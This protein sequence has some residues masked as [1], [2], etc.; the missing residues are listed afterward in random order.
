MK[1]LVLVFCTIW[2][3]SCSNNPVPKPDNL[4]DEEIMTNI[5]FDIAILQATDGSMPLKLSEEHINSTTYIYKKYAIDSLTFYQNQRY[6]AA[7]VKQYKKMYQ[8]VL[9]RLNEE[10][11]AAN[12]IMPPGKEKIK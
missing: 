8:E 11:D 3:L 10:K 4:L 1:K 12:S 5:L 2:L 7:D 9:D 6:Y